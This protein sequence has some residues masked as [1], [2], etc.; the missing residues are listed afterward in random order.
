MNQV[1][2]MPGIIRMDHIGIAVYDLDIA[3]Q[4]YT[5]FL[6]AELISREINKEQMVEEANLTLGAVVFQLLMP[7]NE[8]SK[9]KK[10]LESR[11]P[12]LQQVAFQVKNLDE[13]TKYARNNSVRVI[14]DTPQIGNGNSRINFLHP[15]DCYGVL[16][17][18]IER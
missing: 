8:L 13:A 12:G 15:K 16:I 7:I 5:N 18:L 11:G 2:G 3:I 14:Y 9:I 1:F 6:G 17:E 10:F 4:W